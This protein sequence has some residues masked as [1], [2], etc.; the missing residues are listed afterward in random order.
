MPVE[1][2]R[3]RTE[4]AQSLDRLESQ[5]DSPPSSTPTPGAKG[6]SSSE[7]ALDGVRAI[8]AGSLQEVWRAMEAAVHAGEAE[9]LGVCNFTV[10]ALRHLLSL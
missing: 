10:R 6:T 4:K 3:R 2:S 5:Q 8:D 9:A 1:R 7:P